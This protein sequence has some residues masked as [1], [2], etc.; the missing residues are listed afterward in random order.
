MNVAIFA[1]AFYPSLG[2]VEELCRQLAHEFRRRKLGVI[3]VT[4]RWPR[5]LPRLEEYEGIPVYRL[6]MR[7]PDGS[8]K[9][10]VSY[11]LTHSAIRREMLRILR[12]HSIDVIHL[13]CV[14]CNALYARHAAQTLHLPLVST[15]QGELTMDAR[16]IFQK[17]AFAQGLMHDILDHSDAL[18]GCSRKTI[19]DAAQFRG[20][21]LP[22]ARVIFNGANLDDFRSAA[23]YPHHRP[24]IFAMG[25]LAPQKGFDLLLRAYGASGL[26][27][28]DLLIAGDGDQK[29]SLQALAGKLKLGERAKFLGRADRAQVAQLLTGCSFFVLPSRADEGLPVACVEAMAAGKAVIAA[30]VGGVPEVVENGQTGLLIAAD[31]VTGLIQAM[32][33]LAGDSVLCAEFG[34][35]GRRRAESFAWPRIA[36]QYLE[37]Y[38][39][40]GAR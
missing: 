30:R 11:H 40:A 16:Q 21:T 38:K 9:A 28:H 18:T 24:Y 32:K 19:A 6:A 34:S 17:S 8:F 4:N 14:S 36:D 10:K 5:D 39:Q 1:S 27:E 23:P 37:V 13:Q 26:S 25:R 7:V 3:V 2:G 35:A 15:L 12:E 33:R 31:D 29:E 22:K 20:R